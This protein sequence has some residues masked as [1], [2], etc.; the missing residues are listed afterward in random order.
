VRRQV[1]LKLIRNGIY[2]VTVTRRFAS[3]QQSLAIMEHPAIA[4]Q[5]YC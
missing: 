5:C 3:E 1:A 2:D 4:K